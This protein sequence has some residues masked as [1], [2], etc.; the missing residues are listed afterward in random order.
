MS[1]HQVVNS[2]AGAPPVHDEGIDAEQAIAIR[3][4]QVTGVIVPAGQSLSL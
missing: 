3:V 2:D 4:L 1:I